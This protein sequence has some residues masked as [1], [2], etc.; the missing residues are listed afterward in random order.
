LIYSLYKNEY[1][2][3][4]LTESSI[5]KE[6]SRM[7]KIRGNKPIG[8]IMSCFSFSL[9]FYEIGGQEGGTRPAQEG[10]LA[11]VGGERCWGKGVSA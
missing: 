7:Q 4:K 6:L 8:V 11:S 2:N 1:R 3:L 10:E 5:R 9:F